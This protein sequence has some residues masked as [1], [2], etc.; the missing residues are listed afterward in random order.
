MNK[1]VIVNGHPDR[2]SFS[3]ALQKAYKDGALRARKEVEE[4]VLSDLDFSTNLQFGYR[5]RTDW[6]PDLLTAWNKILQAD[7]LV[8]IFPMWWAS[9]PALMKGFFDRVF[10]PRFAFDYQEKSPFP[11][12]LLNGKTSEIITTMDTPI[13]Y[14][15][16]ILCNP[17]I[18]LL[19]NSILG[20]CGVKNK[21]TTYFSVVKT[22][23]DKQ[24]KKWLSKTERLGA[25]LS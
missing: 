24:R 19:K 20:F 8:F 15:K 6:E 3:H 9:M 18:K 13:W 7:H 10:L 21:R 12:K 4:I 16:W 1:I 11:K 17:G 25:K 14:Y 23:D 5:K 22:S 2:E